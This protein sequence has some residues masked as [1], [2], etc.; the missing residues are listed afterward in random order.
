[1]DPSK[2]VVSYADETRICLLYHKTGD[3]IT[4]HQGYKRWDSYGQ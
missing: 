4:I 2:Y 3:E 1:M